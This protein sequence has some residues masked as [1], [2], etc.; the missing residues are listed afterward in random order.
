MSQSSIEM[1]VKELADAGMTVRTGARIHR[2]SEAAP[3][4]L[5]ELG[6]A[7]LIRW[8]RNACRN[9]PVVMK[10]VGIKYLFDAAGKIPAFVVGIGPSLDQAIDGL[11]LARGRAVILSTDAALRALLANGI[12]PDLVISYDAQDI[13]SKLWESVSE[14]QIPCLFSSC[15]HPSSIASWPGPVLFYN[16]WHQQDELSK[17][18]LPGIFPHIGQ[19]AS[20]ATVGNMALMAATIIGC[21]PVC[22]VGMDFCYAEDAKGVMRYRAKDYRWKTDRGIGLPDGWEPTEIAAL[23][24]NAKRLARSKVITVGGRTFTTDPE[25]EMYLDVFERVLPHFKVPVVNCSPDGMIP[26]SLF[27]PMKLMDAVE[28]YCVT[29]LGPGRT[30]LPHLYKIL[31]DP[32]KNEAGA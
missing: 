11:K 12:K 16:Q 24:D 1:Q 10:G 3:S 25:L 2:S 23:Y 32:R 4:T 8:A 14:K 27:P 18:L 15:S 22:A 6:E 29:H 13:Q 9:Y 31:E 30:V 17:T 21:D 26:H 20:G 5:S 7:W 28:K 19:I